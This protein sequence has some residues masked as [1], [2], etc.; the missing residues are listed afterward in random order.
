MALKGDLKNV[1]LA[2]LFQTLTSNSQQGVLRLRWGDQEKAIYFGRQG[3]TLLNPQITARRRLG[4]MLVEAEVIDRT[5]LDEAL[6]AQARTGHYLGEILRDAGAISEDTLQKVLTRQIEEEIYALFSLETAS[7]EFG[8][9]PPPQGVPAHA[10]FRVDGIVLEAARRVDEWRVIHEKIPDLNA[11]FLKRDD[12]APPD[13]EEL[14]RIWERMNGTRTVLDV[15]DSLLASPFTTAKSMIQLLDA[16]AARAAEPDELVA[17]AQE[18]F[19]NRRADRALKILKRAESVTTD[20]RA[21]LLATIARLYRQA[22]DGAAAAR[23]ILRTARLVRA[24]GDRDQA[25]SQLERAYRLSPEDTAILQ[26]LADIHHEGGDD[27]SEVAYLQR[28]VEIYVSRK[29][30]ERALR[31]LDRIHQRDP[32]HEMM[33]RFY[34]VVCKGAGEHHKAVEYLEELLDRDEVKS[35]ARRV[36]A[37]YR[38]ILELTPSR[39]DV[40]KKL[41]KLKTDQSRVLRKKAFVGASVFAVMAVVALAVLYGI[42]RT[43]GMKELDRA[44][45]LLKHGDLNQAFAVANQVREEH[46]AARSRAGQIIAKTNELREQQRQQ[47]IDEL[48]QSV[49]TRMATLWQ[50]FDDGK[51]ADALNTFITAHRELG[52]QDSEETFKTNMASVRHRVST[53]RDHVV[54]MARDFKMPE[55]DTAIELRRVHDQYDPVF[56]ADRKGDF[57]SFGQIARREAGQPGP[58]VEDFTALADLGQEIVT[59]FGPVEDSLREIRRRSLR[60]SA[61]AEMDS[62]YE[63]ALKAQLDGDIGKAGELYESLLTRYGQGQLTTLFRKEME[64]VTAARSALEALEQRI[65]AGEYQEAHTEAYDIIARFPNL[66]LDKSLLV[67]VALEVAPKS[68][69]VTISAGEV[70]SGHV[71]VPAYGTLTLTAEAEEFD[72]EVRDFTPEKDGVLRVYLHRSAVLKM[73]IGEPVEATAVASDERAYVGTR[74]GHVVAFDLAD[75]S[76]AN[77]F[78]SGS[79]FGI[80]A[81]PVL[82]G[83][84]LFVTAAEG[85]LH[86][87]DKTSLVEKLAIPLGEK[88]QS[89]ADPLITDDRIYIGTEAGS[90]RVFDRRTGRPIYQLGRKSPLRGRPALVHDKLVVAFVGGQLLTLKADTGEVL[91]DLRN[92]EGFVGSLLAY[93]D[94]VFMATETGQLLALDPDTG[95]TVRHATVSQ[96]PATGPVLLEG[97]VYLVAGNKI[98]RFDAKTFQTLTTYTAHETLAGAPAVANDK[99][100]VGGTQGSQYCFARNDGQLLFQSPLGGDGGHTGAVLTS[101]GVLFLSTKGHAEVLAP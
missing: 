60:L 53:E 18:C 43:A 33:S 87:I 55:L 76:V 27:V 66:H 80:R 90:L 85:K 65:A 45:R 86:I 98:V 94:L 48:R 70:K 14:K 32:T 92:G 44:E 58:Y 34:V 91:R 23:V 38:Q 75:G 82:C 74:N 52:Q 81:T 97:D 71:R 26:E 39:V 57:L 64:H 101:R 93:G 96:L 7:F 36:A 72:R 21:A 68:A 51:L 59:Q 99:V 88:E 47:R 30:D 2:D 35:D 25:R 24:A 3:I 77:T 10:Y 16:G 13:D 37:I 31:A 78:D 6:A 19:R 61:L 46:F 89:R 40:S 54:S 50:Q 56:N 83:G 9:V 17:A 8:E 95:S 12:V 79:F 73:D 20:Q 15:A 42:D 63:A 67:P 29:D 11:I 28:L 49:A 5:T 62:M 4:D 69:H 41:K 100:Y 22:G 1:Q 84:E